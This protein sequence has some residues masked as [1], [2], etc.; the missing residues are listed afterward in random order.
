M[1]FFL[2]Y[3]H[4]PRTE[5]EREELYGRI[6]WMAFWLDSF[7]T[8]GG[9]NIGLESII[10]LIPVIGD[11]IGMFASM[12]Q[13]YLSYLFNIPKELMLRM[14]LNVVID[15]LVGLVPWI[16]DILDVFYKSNQYNLTILTN[17]L[18]ENKLVDVHRYNQEHPLN[19]ETK[20]DGY[21]G[22]RT[23]GINFRFLLVEHSNTSTRLIT[24]KFLVFEMNMKD[25]EETTLSCTNLEVL[26]IRIS[27]MDTKERIDRTIN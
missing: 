6:R 15:F 26:H 11:F 18:L 10:G 7:A 25:S 19:N 21:S 2:K 22:S 12:Y 9:F 24:L 17:W 14:L 16:G 1:D 23:A 3:H 13:V 5:K 20:A 27:G 8:V 4:P